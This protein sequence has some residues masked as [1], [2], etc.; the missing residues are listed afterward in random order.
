M[1]RSRSKK[2]DLIALSLKENRDALAKALEL[3]YKEMADINS[4]LAEYAV[5][6]DNESL[7]ECEEKLT[8]CD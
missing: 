7:S 5:V 3:G 4:E 1:Q 8:E 6:S 2:G